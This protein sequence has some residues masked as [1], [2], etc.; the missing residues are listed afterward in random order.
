M[1]PSITNKCPKT[2]KPKY[3]VLLD[4]LKDYFMFISSCRDCFYPHR[5]IIYNNMNV[6]ISIR[7]KKS[8]HKINA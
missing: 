2:S 8:T 4:E 6:L 1:C 5:Y 7:C 3:D